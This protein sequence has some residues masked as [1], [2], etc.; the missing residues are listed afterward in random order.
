MNNKKESFQRYAELTTSELIELMKSPRL[1]SA[2]VAI[3]DEI[4]DLRG[5]SK[6]ARENLKNTLNVSA[7]PVGAIDNF[8]YKN[9]SDRPRLIAL[10]ALFALWGFISN[11]LHMVDAQNTGPKIFFLVFAV[12]NIFL[13]YGLWNLKKWARSYLVFVYSLNIVLLW[14]IILAL[15]LFEDSWKLSTSELAQSVLLKKMSANDF[16]KAAIYKGL[17]IGALVKSFIYGLLI[18]YFFRPNILRLFQ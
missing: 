6:T 3:V 17:F 16:F 2:D 4:L 18:A 1:S 5:I 14:L 11:L 15:Y 13:A 8:D 7:A 9:F 12:L 10:I